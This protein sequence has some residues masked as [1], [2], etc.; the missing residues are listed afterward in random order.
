M[1]KKDVAII[2]VN[3][4][5]ADH[6]E[7]CL[8]SVYTEA[9][10]VTQQ[11]IV[12]DN[13]S[14]DG[15]VDLII[16]KFPKVQLINSEKNLG[17]AAGVNLGASF[18]QSRFLLLL[19]PDTIILNH[20]VD[21]I[22]EFA[23][24][25]PQ[26]GLYGGRTFRADGELEFSSCWG[27]PTL[28][29]TALFALGL[30]TLAPRNKW[31][32]PESL[33]RWKRDT[34]KEVGVI[35]GCFLLTTSQIWKGLEGLDERYFMYGEDVDFSMRARKRGHRP[36]ICPDATLVHEVGQSSETPI[37][38]TLLLFR[39]KS[40]LIRTH[41]KGASMYCGLLSLVLGTGLRALI[42]LGNCGA[43]RDST[44]CRWITL[45]RKRREWVKG[46]S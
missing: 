13:N 18:A 41:W 28:W 34:V 1:N 42:A 38:K 36:V 30:T 33:G 7:K 45:W 21:T 8:N 40:C 46:Y 6:I 43:R 25:E 3:Y 15:T 2:I 37:H 39:G 16:K 24:K 26:Y 4:N 22:V 31:L 14:K 5:S 12:V 10:G 19:N 29:S 17:F 35:T 9:R 11:I 20:A 44:S 27:E 32:D 23:D